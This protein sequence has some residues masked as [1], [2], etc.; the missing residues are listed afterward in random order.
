MG[1]VGL[2]VQIV[3]ALII[4]LVNVDVVIVRANCKPVTIRRVF[5]HFYPFT[6][7]KKCGNFI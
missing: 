6:R 5:H 4:D 7:V 2:V 1:V 3:L